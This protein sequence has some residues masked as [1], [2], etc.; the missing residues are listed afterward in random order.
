MQ[1]GL[2]FIYQNKSLSS[3]QVYGRMIATGL[4]KT[5]NNF[6]ISKYPHFHWWRI[7]MRKHILAPKLTKFHCKKVT[8]VYVFYNSANSKRNFHRKERRNNGD[9]SK[10]DKYFLRNT[11]F[12][13]QEML[14][15][16][17]KVILMFHIIL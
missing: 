14:R 11:V 13:R 16:Y 2:L 7:K 1:S 12:E 15:I 4:K 8:I 5:K 10:R 17:K 9:G 3:C 6:F